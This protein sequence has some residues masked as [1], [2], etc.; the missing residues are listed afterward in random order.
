[1]S[2][3]DV[4]AYAPEHRPAVGVELVPVSPVLV[5]G[6]WPDWLRD[7]SDVLLPVHPW[8]RHRYGLPAGRATL[9]AR[10]LMSLRT[11]AVGGRPWHLKTA[12]DVQMTSAVRVVSPA[13]VHNGPA[14]SAL[15]S[16]LAIGGIE[17][18]PETAA[19]AALVDGE[20]SRSLAAAVRRA[21]A[22]PAVPFAALSAPSP[23]T[24]RALLT[25]A[26]ALA[27][28]TPGRF[29][30]QIVAVALPPL[31]TLLDLGVALEAHGQNTLLVLDRGRPVRL[32]YR[33]LGGVRISPARLRT[34]GIEPPPIRGDLVSDDPVTLRTKLLAALS[35]VLGE[36]VA[37]A[38]REYGEP[39]EALWSH[40]AEAVRVGGAGLP[41]G[42]RRLLHS[43]LTGPWPT[44]ATTAM[45]L[46]TDP[47]QDVWTELPNPL[48]AL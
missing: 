27:G 23:A 3:E 30:A 20:P 2:T 11:L 17:V 26:V 41:A 25:E 43:L 34:Q 16:G 47:L 22:V 12:V 21:P 35:T 36:L 28:T 8:Q 18:L 7:G 39:P 32:L 37:T 9:P 13:A 24:G 5:T 15:L 42:A 19:A 6:A 48:E 10:P 40:V 31:F 46:A 1:M 38:G 33:D 14:L 44:K 45:R 4:L 29:L